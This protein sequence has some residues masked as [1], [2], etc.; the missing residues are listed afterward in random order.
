MTGRHPLPE[1]RSRSPRFLSKAKSA[2]LLLSLVSS[3][4]AAP[5]ILV[6]V[7]P[8]TIAELQK[9]DPMIRLV[10]PGEEAKVV[11]EETPSIIADSTILHDGK[12][13]TLVPKGAVVHT[14]KALRERLNKKPVGILLPWQDFLTRNR[15]WIVSHEVSF[16]QAAGTETIPAEHCSAWKKQEKLVVAVHNQGPISVQL[17]SADCP[18]P[19]TLTHR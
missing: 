16:D 12:N 13:W 8:E 6:R 3:A 7:Q 19:S 5:P 9:R 15:T 18:T 4:A 17:A 11:R 10:K 2:L 14:P 1:T